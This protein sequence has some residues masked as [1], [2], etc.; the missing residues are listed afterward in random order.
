MRRFS[1]IRTIAIVALTIMGTSAAL[2]CAY[3]ETYNFYL[4]NTY[5]VDEDALLPFNEQY[6]Q[7]KEKLENKTDAATLKYL[8]Y[9]GQYT[10]ICE[11]LQDV[12]EYPT[13]EQLAARE[14]TLRKINDYAGKNTVA[15]LKAPCALLYM[16]SN[17]VMKQYAKNVSFWKQTASKMPESCYKEKMK[18]IYANALLNSGEWK[19]ACDIYAQQEDWTSL[20]WAMRKYRS[21]AGVKFISDADPNSP[22]LKYLVQDF[23]NSTQESIDSKYD[24]DVLDYIGMPLIQSPEALQMVELSKRNAARKDVDDPCIWQTAAAALEYLLGDA[25]NAAKDIEKALT[26]KGEQRS[27]DHARAINMIIKTS[28]ADFDEGFVADELKW[29]DSKIAEECS[30][31]E[32]I[33]RSYFWRMRERI[34]R[35]N[36]IPAL[37]NLAVNDSD[38]MNRCILVEAAENRDDINNVYLSAYYDVFEKHC[39]SELIRFLDFIHTNPVSEL[40]RYYLSVTK[41][42]ETTLKDIIGTRL[43]AEGCFDDA[44]TY[45]EQVPLSYLKNL[46]INWYMANRKFDVAQWEHSQTVPQDI[47]PEEEDKVDISNNPKI[48]F[49]KRMIALQRK[50]DTSAG[51]ARREAAFKMGVLYQQASIYGQCW[52]ISHYGR[53]FYDQPSPLDKDFSQAAIDMFEIASAISDYRLAGRALCGI[54]Y[55]TYRMR[56]NCEENFYSSDYEWVKQDPKTKTAYSRLNNFIAGHPET[57]F[58]TTKCDIAAVFR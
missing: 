33:C 19:K 46:N 32:T 53:G 25:D 50:M 34:N 10:E 48:E 4:F 13:K 3:E 58:L 2:A 16:R 45:L 31:P 6:R 44:L 28:A 52:F 18:N 37:K 39:S 35:K 11:Q 24:K 5:N 8:G 22:A 15:A 1:T 38:A 23:V 20:K 27:L 9:L 42:D 30:D 41:I 26:M 43:I 51:N 54:A 56:Q 12:W 14:I 21:Y 47:Y 36:I 7:E 49:C 17:M 29:L 55:T 57:A 40:D